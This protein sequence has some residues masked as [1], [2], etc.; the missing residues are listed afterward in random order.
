M[1]ASRMLWYYLWVA[2]HVLQG[3]ILFAMVRRGLIRQF[4]MFFLYTGFEILQSALLLVVCHFV[5]YF[6]S[7]YFQVYAVGLAIST[8]IRFGVI[9]ELFNHFFTRYPALTGAG[10]LLFRGAT[11]MLLVVAVGL[12]VSAPGNVLD[13][14][15]KDAAYASLKTTTFAADR[16]VSVLQCGLLISLFLFSRYFVLSW[17]SPAFGI[18]L[19]L[20]TFAI[21][22]LATTALRLYVP[23][24]DETFD[25]AGMGI[26]HLCVLVWIVYLVRAEREPQFTVQTFPKYD[27]E[28]WNRELERLIQQ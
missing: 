5:S 11:L 22:E 21:A 4:P 2:P 14:V 20:G 15:L 25:V 26:Y 18:A 28:I 7:V 24:S 13:H 16:A 17:R 9:Y 19:G 27:L 1:P 8:A 23:A 12:A 6:G 10:K 3:I